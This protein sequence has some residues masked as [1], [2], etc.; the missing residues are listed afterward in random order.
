MWRSS[1]P[2]DCPPLSGPRGTSSPCR[3]SWWARKP[4]STPKRGSCADSG[5][6]EGRL[7]LGHEGRGGVAVVGGGTADPLCLGLRVQGLVER[8]GCTDEQLPLDLPVRDGRSGRET[9]G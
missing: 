1:A 7:L 2:G 6:G 9:Q 4:T 3:R 5:S 8:A